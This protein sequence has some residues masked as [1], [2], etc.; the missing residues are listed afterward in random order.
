[1]AR[2]KRA[3]K[4]SIAECGSVSLLTVIAAEPAPDRPSVGWGP[5]AAIHDTPNASWPLPLSPLEV[6]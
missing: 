6:R 4:G 2:V 1:M 5:G 3:P